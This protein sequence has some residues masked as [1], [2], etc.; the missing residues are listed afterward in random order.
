MTYM[1]PS[2]RPA[3]IHSI[4]SYGATLVAASNALKSL[5]GQKHPKHKYNL[6]HVIS[7][8]RVV[9]NAQI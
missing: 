4:Y 3:M 2:N 5:Q 8:L 6:Y 1:V 9:S 7:I